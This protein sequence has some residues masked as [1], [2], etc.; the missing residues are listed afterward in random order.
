M[1][2]R[3][4]NDKMDSYTEA[5]LTVNPVCG[6]MPTTEWPAFNYVFECT[7]GQLAGKYIT[8]QPTTAFSSDSFEV[9]ELYILGDEVIEQKSTIHGRF[10]YPV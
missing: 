6:T 10:G 4:G 2:T 1:Q 5:T 8:I 9:A 7:P 3:V